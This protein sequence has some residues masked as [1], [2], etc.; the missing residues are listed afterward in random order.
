[1]HA[2]ASQPSALTALTPASCSTY[3]SSRGGWLAARG[4]TMPPAR[5]TASVA[6]RYSAPGDA[7]RPTRGD[8]PPRDLLATS[9]DTAELSLSD[10]SS[11]FA[12]LSSVRDR[13][14]ERRR[15]GNVVLGSP[16]GNTQHRRDSGGKLAG[17]AGARSRGD[18]R[19]PNTRVLGRIGIA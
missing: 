15:R 17:S 13:V 5:H 3:S 10:A 11:T 9:R 4:T 2:F 8:S 12:Y 6:A 16:D 14:G 18:P 1:M 19:S 7:Y